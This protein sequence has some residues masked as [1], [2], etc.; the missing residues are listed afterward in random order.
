VRCSVAVAHQFGPCTL[1]VDLNRDSIFEIKRIGLSFD[2][3]FNTNTETLGGRVRIK[4][5]D[6]HHNMVDTFF[7][8][9][10]GSAPLHDYWE[11]CSP[12]PTPRKYL[13]VC[14]VGKTLYALGG[15]KQ[16]FNGDYSQ[17]AVNALEAY[18]SVWTVKDSMKTARYSFACGEY[19]GSIYVFGGKSTQGYIK[20]IERYEIATNK[21]SSAGNMPFLRASAASCVYN[22][23]LY[24]FGGRKFYQQGIDSVGNDIQAYDFASNQWSIVTGH[25]NTPR[26]DFQAVVIGEK[27]Y[28]IGGLGGSLY[29]TDDEA[30]ADVEVY[31]PKSNQC[32][33]DPQMYSAHSYFA[34][35]SINDSIFTIGGISGISGSKETLINTISVFDPIKAVWKE[36]IFPAPHPEGRSGCGAGVVNGK[37][38][39]VGGG[40]DFS[41]N[42]PGFAD[43]VVRKYYP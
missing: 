28:L 5:I 41:I 38:V 21:W 20:S 39:I 33:S 32:S 22:N 7:T 26:H 6:S 40:T 23:K 12:M 19:N 15:C 35:V 24:L 9:T 42:N 29:S 8:L 43:G 18:D 17:K 10:I 1:Y 2:T 37:I 3:L 4:I 25:M 30:L 31:D 34:A 14:V 36:K 16:F 27:I 11:E 13:S